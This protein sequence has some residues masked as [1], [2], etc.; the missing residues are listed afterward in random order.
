M[1]CSL[2]ILSAVK[3][4]RTEI[5]RNEMIRVFVQHRLRDF[6]VLPSNQHY[7]NL[8]QK[9]SD[10]RDVFSGIA[11]RRVYPVRALLDLH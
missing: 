3:Q 11:D 9:I 5:D 10:G 8:F 6:S 1:L 4:K 7:D 2:N